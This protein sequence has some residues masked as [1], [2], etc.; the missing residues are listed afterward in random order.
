MRI[1]FW[2]PVRQRRESSFGYKMISEKALGRKSRCLLCTGLYKSGSG[3]HEDAGNGRS[4]SLSGGSGSCR[5]NGVRPVA[6]QK[7]SFCRK[8]TKLAGKKIAGCRRGEQK[9]IL[10]LLY[11]FVWNKSFTISSLVQN[12]TFSC[13]CNIV[14]GI[15]GCGSSVRIRFRIPGCHAAPSDR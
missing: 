9:Y 5:S 1:R 7:G 6:A 12:I 14:A 2:T 3:Y 15:C 4:I 8:R 10:Q 13:F 11:K